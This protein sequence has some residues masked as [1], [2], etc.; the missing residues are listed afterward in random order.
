M[1]LPTTMPLSIIAK[2]N[3]IPV[4]H[5]FGEHNLSQKNRP[6][7]RKRMIDTEISYNNGR[8]NKIFATKI[9]S[10]YNYV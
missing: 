4:I 2:Y 9:T 7:C 10:G 8:Y 6:T 5:K 1:V 3:R